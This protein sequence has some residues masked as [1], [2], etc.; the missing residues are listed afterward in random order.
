MSFVA[1]KSSIIITEIQ[2]APQ[3]PEP[4]WVEL[5]NFSSIS[6]YC[7]DCMFGDANTLRQLPEFELH[8]GEYLIITKDSAALKKSYPYLELLNIIQISLPSLNNTGDELRLYSGDK[9]LD[10]IV[11]GGSY[12]KGKS[13][14]RIINEEA[15]SISNTSTT[16]SGNGTPGHINSN[17]PKEVDLDIDSIIQK[18]NKFELYLVNNGIKN[19]EL[20]SL[21]LNN[22]I[23]GVE[24]IYAIE[25]IILS[26]ENR[27]YEFDIP[28]SD[29][30]GY[31]TFEI[32]IDSQIDQER[33]SMVIHDTIF[34]FFSKPN[35]DFVFSEILFEPVEGMSEFFEIY[36]SGDKP[37]NLQGFI[38]ADAA[39]NAAPIAAEIEYVINPETYLAIGADSTLFD[40]PNIGNAV[41]SNQ[42]PALNNDKDDIIFS[43]PDYGQRNKII[44]IFY[45]SD[46]HDGR[47]GESKGISLENIAPKTGGVEFRTCSDE[48][49]ATPGKANSWEWSSEIE[50]DLIIEPNPF[51]YDNPTVIKYDLFEGQGY[52]RALILNEELQIVNRLI[53]GRPG[54]GI[55]RLNWDG[56][57]SEGRRL[58]V[59]IYI[60]VIEGLEDK[61]G[62]SK[63]LR[64]IVVIGK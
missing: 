16:S 15:W 3:S 29:K 39:S 5:L 25:E 33:D 18:D 58:P 32:R 48:F 57:D 42:F 21:Q 53:P 55:G 31:S 51:D 7:S 56:T 45:D 59:G 60:L 52:I 44:S 13:I 14:E 37:L 36:Y 64:E 35:K 47:L 63:I 10:S 43:Y 30:Y 2:P 20:G 17:A 22:S 24:T 26:N 34:D 6:Y 8:A 62:Q 54:S 19:L 38:I 11:Y 9:L 46:M 61:T 4:E 28:N 49:G 50:M 12:V 41:V 1:G 23:S 27:K 40:Y